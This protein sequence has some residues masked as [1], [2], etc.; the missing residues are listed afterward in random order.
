[1]YKMLAIFMMAGMVFAG[2]QNEHQDLRT[3]DSTSMPAPSDAQTVELTGEPLLFKEEKP[4][5]A[6]NQINYLIH[7]YQLKL[8]AAVNTNTFAEV[9]PYLLPGSS[10]YDEQK[11]LVTDLFARNV[12]ESIVSSKVYGYTIEG[13]Q[14]RIEVTEQ[15]KIHY[16]DKGAR[17]KNYNWL[18]TAKQADGRLKLS[19]IEA[20]DTYERDM[21]QRSSAV[22]GDGYY[23]DELF[24]NYPEILEK[25]IR[26]LDLTDIR[27]ISGSETVFEQ[28][29]ALISW[30]RKSGEEVT[31][32][33]TTVQQDPIRQYGLELDFVD[34][35][36]GT[37][38]QMV[39]FQLSER[40]NDQGFGGHAVID[41]FSDGEIDDAFASDPHAVI[42]YQYIRLHPKMPEY[43][44]KV[45]GRAE[46]EEIEDRIYHA[47]KIE[48]YEAGSNGRLLQTI[49]LEPTDTRDGMNLGIQI[50]DMNFDG[51]L[52]LCIQSG[53]PAGPNTPYKYWLW[54]SNSSSLEANLELEEI[55]APEFDSYTQTVHSL[56]RVHAAEYSDV[57]YR[58]INGSPVLVS[59][60]VHKYDAEKNAWQET[61]SE[62]VDG[63]MQITGQY[64]EADS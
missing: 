22:K 26:T 55:T 46:G 14:Y 28:Q 49:S 13:D 7:E 53:I 50:E 2:C 60:V 32:Q 23:A 34:G 37:G 56:I 21:E 58:Y 40:R 47:E 15:I 11:K 36:Q 20:W 57:Y 35:Y 6:F 45:Y 9:E 54:N 4:D 19:G 52:D 41:Y 27:R 42:R 31:I 48:L 1:M 30:F 16:P 18:Y 8:A 17:L 33:A 29:K 25:A 10:L 51:Y 5:D 62:L 24:S 64:E 39:Y 43:L 12:K 3:V 38:T 44:V 61:I 63:Q 59:S